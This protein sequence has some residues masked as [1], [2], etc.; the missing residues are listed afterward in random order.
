MVVS[1]RNVMAFVQVATSDE[2]AVH[3]IGEGTENEG[4]VNSPAAHDAD[5]FD[6]SRILLSGNSSQIGS[7]VRSPIAHEAKD[8]RLEFKSR[9]HSV[10]PSS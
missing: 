7:A 1:I 5:Q 4:Q 6:I 3:S 2:H 10:S 9:T 8:I